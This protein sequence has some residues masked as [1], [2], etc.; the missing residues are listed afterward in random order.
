MKG[1]DNNCDELLIWP[2]LVFTL[3]DSQLCR[4]LLAVLQI[5]KDSHNLKGEMDPDLTY[6][7]GL[8][9]FL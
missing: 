4:V 8:F 9:R 6:H 7:N 1:C 5:R 2:I 3:T